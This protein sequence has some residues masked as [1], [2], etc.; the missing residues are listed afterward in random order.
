MSSRPTCDTGPCLGQ[1][2]GAA[3]AAAQVESLWSVYDIRSPAQK[4]SQQPKH[5]PQQEISQNPCRQKRQTS[6]CALKFVFVERNQRAPGAC[7]A[8]V[9]FT[10]AREEGPKVPFHRQW[11]PALLSRGLNNR[12]ICPFCHLPTPSTLLWLLTS[13]SSTG[14]GGTS[15]MICKWK[16]EWVSGVFS[17][18]LPKMSEVQSK[19]GP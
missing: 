16:G 15:L 10:L 2:A 7:V 12:P 8:Q 13:L 19:H 4:K 5:I 6:V 1:R 11:G 14:G 17:L 9:L 18:L 3:R